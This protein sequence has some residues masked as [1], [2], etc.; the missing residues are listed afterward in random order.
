MLNTPHLL[1][2]TVI[3]TH[4][5]WPVA[6]IIG[7]ASHFALDS[8]PHADTGTLHCKNKKVKNYVWTK[9]DWS[10][11][12][13]DLAVAAALGLLVWWKSGFSIAIAAGAG[14]AVL[15]DIF[16]NVPWWKYWFRATKVGKMA[17][18]VHSIFQFQLKYKYWYWGVV[19]QIIIIGGSLWYWLK[20]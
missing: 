19:T 5:D 4:F 16:D 17:H 9:Q 3:G 1:A 2:G 6:L 15:P 13:I 12:K 18:K 7:I 20:Y 8:I 10:L 14:G 11:I